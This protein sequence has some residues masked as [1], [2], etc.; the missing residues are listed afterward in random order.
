[1]R[2]PHC[3]DINR[4]SIF[5]SVRSVFDFIGRKN[6]FPLL[7]IELGVAHLMKPISPFDYAA[8]QVRYKKIYLFDG[9]DVFLGIIQLVGR[10]SGKRVE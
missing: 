2:R 3:L 1:M 4:F 6:L 8:E 7:R 10:V 5:C 9:R